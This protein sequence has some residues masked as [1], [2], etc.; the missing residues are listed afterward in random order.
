[1]RYPSIPLICLLLFGSCSSPPRPPAVD[2]SKRRPVNAAME[3]DLQSCRSEVRNA[4]IALSE[5]QRIAS[6][7]MASAAHLAQAADPSHMRNIVYVLSFP[8]GRSRVE[9]VD[10]TVSRLIE[11]ARDAPLIVLRGRTD[12][13]L[14]T[15][16]ESRVARE[17]AESVQALLQQ[18]GIEPARIRATWQP[19]G[20]HIADNDLAGGR[21]LNRRVEVE[22]YRTAPRADVPFASSGA[23]PEDRPAL[24]TTTSEVKH[25]H[26]LQ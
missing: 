8:F 16:A 17:R 9:T 7:A 19:V 14:L 3:V 10:P 26:E 21:A 18:S 12:G 20:D 11:D 2:E 23:L 4:R 25:G 13:V 6:A 24:P 15:P 22:I 5:G 1:M